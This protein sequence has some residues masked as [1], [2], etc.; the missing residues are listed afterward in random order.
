M[1]HFSFLNVGHAYRPLACPD[2]GYPSGFSKR[3]LASPPIPFPV[4]EV[5]VIHVPFTTSPGTP[6][7]SGQL[8]CLF[9]L[10]L[11]CTQGADVSWLSPTGLHPPLLGFGSPRNR[12]SSPSL[13][14]DGGSGHVYE[15]KTILSTFTLSFF[16]FFCCCDHPLFALFPRSQQLSSFPFCAV[17]PNYSLTLPRYP[18]SSTPTLHAHQF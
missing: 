16:S 14:G 6:R 4:V 1:R 2:S 13:I 11:F 17:T 10:P 18:L 9:F 12:G 5:L 3:L 8:F 7:A 15:V